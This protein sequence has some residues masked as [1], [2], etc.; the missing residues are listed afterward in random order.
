MKTEEAKSIVFFPRNVWQ[1]IISF[2]ELDD[3]VTLK[4]TSKTLCEI[5]SLPEFDVV[6]KLFLKR[7]QGIDPT[8]SITNSPGTF[9][10]QFYQ[11][12]GN[13]IK[14]QNEEI[15]HF[16]SVLNSKIIFRP[17]LSRM[18]AT[19]EATMLKNALQSILAT[20]GPHITLI[21]IEKKHHLL[22]DL[23]TMMI[24]N[25]IKQRKALDIAN[26]HLDLSFLDLTRIP[27]AIFLNPEYKQLWQSLTS[28][29]IALQKICQI[30]GEIKICSSLQHL[31]MGSNLLKT[32]PDEIGECKE[33]V[34]ISC[35]G[36]QLAALPDSI[37][38][39]S[40]LQSLDCRTN[41]LSALPNMPESCTELNVN[42]NCLTKM[43]QALR[44]KFGNSWAEI[45]L[46]LQKKPFLKRPN[47]IA[48]PSVPTSTSGA[49]ISS[50]FSSVG[51]YLTSYLPSFSSSNAQQ[52][53]AQNDEDDK[54]GPRS[55]KYPKPGA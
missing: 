32:L 15:K 40:K 27:S 14:S 39:L 45:T 13:V 11:Q 5:V 21:E 41:N 19:A 51:N 55:A 26:G 52:N 10:K 48:A 24:A 6:W 12:I 8:V 4:R 36:N 42:D 9:Q 34:A 17:Y 31:T 18:I 1:E 23:C 53:S 38:Q 54:Q 16:Q 37:S 25:A 43:P 46:K 47:E 22:N 35:S 44:D 7:L 29:N 30:S 33:L 2:L 28:L 50:A 20:Q 49:S 3:I